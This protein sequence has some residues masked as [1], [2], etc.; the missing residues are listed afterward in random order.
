MRRGGRRPRR[1]RR[2]ADGCGNVAGPAGDARSRRHRRG[3]RRLRPAG[4]VPGRRGRRGAP[5]PGHA[6]RGGPPGTEEQ[7]RD[8]PVREPRPGSDPAERIWLRLIDEYLWCLTQGLGEREEIDAVLCEVIGTDEG[9]L[10]KIRTLDPALLEPRLAAL[11]AS[12][13]N[14][15]Q[16]TRSLL[17]RVREADV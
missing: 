5:N 11:E 13:G 4:V 7:E 16:P 10:Q 17:E 6:A 14:R 2:A 1:C 8:L 12:L 15:Y 9:P 3:P